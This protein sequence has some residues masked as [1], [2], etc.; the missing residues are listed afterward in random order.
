MLGCRRTAFA[1]R[2]DDAPECFR[3]ESQHLFDAF[4][5]NGESNYFKSNE[6]EVNDEAKTGKDRYKWQ[7]FFKQGTPPLLYGYRANLRFL[8]TYV[9]RI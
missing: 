9:K 3:T 5:V 6:D 7:E 2:I 4:F 8:R 1:K